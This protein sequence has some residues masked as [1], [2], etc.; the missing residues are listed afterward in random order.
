MRNAAREHSDR[1]L[2]LAP[3]LANGKTVEGVTALKLGQPTL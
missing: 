3:A 1:D 2:R